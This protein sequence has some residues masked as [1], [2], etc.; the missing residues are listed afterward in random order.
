MDQC[1]IFGLTYFSP[2]YIFIDFEK[3]IQNAAQQVWPAINIKGCCFHLGQ[4]WWKKIQCLGLSKTYKKQNL[5]ESNFFKF[6]FGLYFLIPND[7][8]DFFIEDIMPKLPANKNIKLFI[9][10][11]LKT[12]IAS[13]STFPPNLWAEFSTISNRTTNS[14][15]SFHA[16]L[17]SLFYTLHPNIY[18]F[19]DALK[20]IQSNTYIQIRSKASYAKNQNTT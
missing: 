4:S 2:K 9:D 10:Y 1:T 18:I 3:F 6:F 7:V 19:I 20:E 13:D 16:K 11:I 17:N 14:C 12:Y 5:E 8:Y 15:E